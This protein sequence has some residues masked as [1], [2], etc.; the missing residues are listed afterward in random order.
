[1]ETLAKIRILIVDD[2]YFVRVGLAE[3][4]EMEPDMAVVAQAGNGQQA[5]EE[6][7]RVCPDVLLADL[8]LPG[9][10][11]AR[12]TSIVRKEFPGVRTIILSTYHGDEDI[13]RAFQA[14]AKG[15]L[16]KSMD[17]ETLVEAIRT[18][19][20]GKT[21]IPPVV[22]ERLS[23]RMPRP[24]LSARELEVL[25]LIVQGLANK[26]IGAALNITEG[27]VKLHVRKVLEKLNVS[28][29]TQA[30]TAALRSGIIR[31]E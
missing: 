6:Y 30:A 23:R 27:T 5:I 16:L 15:Y 8:L 18:V 7:R 20:S 9:M 3:C 22:A 26:E 24:D 11:G 4:I 17:R 1:M 31:L 21:Y 12:L 25:H 14:G 19:H 10:D 13:Y 29:R 2:H 28:D